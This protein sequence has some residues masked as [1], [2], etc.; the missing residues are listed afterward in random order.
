M[1]V[2]RFA[3]GRVR[4]MIGLNPLHLTYPVRS[5]DS[6]Q[7]PECVSIFSTAGLGGMSRSFHRLFRDNLCR[8]KFVYE[9]RPVLL[10]SWEA[11]FCDFDSTRLL[12]LADSAVDLGVKLFVLDDGWFGNKYPRVDTT[13]GLGDWVPNA[14]RF[15][16]GWSNFV[17]K[18]TAL[19]TNTG[20]MQF[21]LWVEP[22][23]V[24][25]KSELYEKH[26][27]WVLYSG[28]HERSEKRCQLVLDLGLR[29]VQDYIIESMS[30][31]LSSANISYIKWDCN[32]GIHEMPSPA[33][34][35]NY[36]LGVYRVLDALITQFP[37]VLFEGCASGG[38]RFDAGILHYWAQSWTSDN[39]D[40][41]DRLFIQFG[42][43]VAYPASSMGC[44]VS[45][46]PNEQVGRTTPLAFRAHVAMMGGSF[47]FEL[48]MEH[49]SP[50]ERSAVPALIAMS[51]T[52]N[53]V[54]LHG[55]MYRLALPD[56]SNVAAALYLDGDK[57]VL[58]V[59]RIRT[60]LRTDTGNIKL[61]GLREHAQY[62][63]DGE[64]YT[65][66]CLMS[67]GL[68]LHWKNADYQSKVM[69]LEAM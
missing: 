12:T 14:A 27:D 52:I 10:N 37:D 42:T 40:A 26:P 13:A 56:E 33:H 25:P 19:S 51:E 8:S 45:A 34:S 39:T 43:T 4:A 21:G 46:C 22:E 30:R 61:Q 48:A 49:M 58:F 67:A 63:L 29:S 62:R 17:D 59:F 65:G 32:R 38:G 53:P 15:P 31:L 41:L 50:E 55:D 16:E 57:G 3:Y 1:D 44:H 36:V 7:S 35:H 20:P 54:I 5:G 9:P 66:A 69:M 23:M 60:T 11:V 64:V 28:E 24:N 68:K 2:E 47:G 6:F 18:I